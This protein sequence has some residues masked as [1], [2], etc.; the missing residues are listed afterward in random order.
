MR[1]W[2]G[3]IYEGISERCLPAA[4]L[5]CL[6]SL[7]RYIDK[8]TLPRRFFGIQNIPDM[9]DDKGTSLIFVN[10]KAGQAIIEQ[11][12]DKMQYKEVDIVEAVRY[13]PAAIKSAVA[14]PHRE[15]FFEEL[16]K[17]TF[18]ELVKKYCTD[19]LS[20]RVKRKTKLV[21]SA[22]LKKLGVLGFAKRV[23]RR[24]K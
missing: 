8:V 19:K 21:A 7:R 9:D 18:D 1:P 11:I 5:L 15:K 10:S 23:L 20:V 2:I 17:L 16:D 14:N 4:F 6:Y 24:A 13:N 12:V 3:F 22:I